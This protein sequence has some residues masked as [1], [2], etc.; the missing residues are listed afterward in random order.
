VKAA[1]KGIKEVDPHAKVL[2]CSTSG[3][4][5]D[6]QKFIKMVL[7]V[8]PFDI[9]TIHPYRSALDDE[10]FIRELQ[11]MHALTARADGK[12]KP[13]W[14]TEMGW[15]TDVVTGVSEREQAS[16]LAR[17]YLCAM[18][19]Q[20]ASN[21][22]WYDFRDDGECP[23]Y[24]EHRMGVVRCD[25]FT[26]KPAYRALASVC[27]TLA[28]Q[29]LRKTLDF[30][31]GIMAYEFGRRG[32]NTIVLWSRRRD[33][34]LKLKVEGTALIQDLMGSEYQLTESKS[35]S[36]IVLQADSPVFII[37]SAIRVSAVSKPVFLEMPQVVQPGGPMQIRLL[38]VKSLSGLTCRIDP[39]KGWRVTRT[40]SLDAGALVCDLLVPADEQP[41]ERQFMIT[42]R[43]DGRTFDLPARFRVYP[44]LVEF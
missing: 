14:I 41:G 32:Q 18:V 7:A 35:G 4:S 37:G 3:I 39:P 9:L 33:A 20:A 38:P 15:S 19:S 17:S 21:I 2:A 29:K 1:Y 26:P 43:A 5:A 40:P 11:G 24:V 23:Y 36:T 42:F 10:G 6:E 34:I 30:G 13:V 8:A 31:T 27:R 22:S 44:P 16:L 25:D 12:A 28:G